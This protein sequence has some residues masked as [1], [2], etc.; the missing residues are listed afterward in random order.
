MGLNL[1]QTEQ[2]TVEARPGP[3]SAVPKLLTI[4]GAAWLVWIVWSTGGRLARWRPRL[5]PL[6]AALVAL[7]GLTR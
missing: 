4:L 7:L 5:E 3:G 1:E 2:P 6:R